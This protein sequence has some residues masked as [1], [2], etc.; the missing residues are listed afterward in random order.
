MIEINVIYQLYY[1][2][3]NKRI[4]LLKLEISELELNINN[5]I[6]ILEK[7]KNEINKYS[8]YYDILDR[9]IKKIKNNTDNTII[10]Y[11]NIQILNYNS[12]YTPLN[13]KRKEVIKL[14]KQV[15]SSVIYKKIIKK[16]NSK[17]IDKIIKDH[18]TFILPFSLGTLKV[19]RKTNKR[20]RPNWGISNK[21]YKLLITQNKI[22][23]KLT[24]HLEAKKNNKEY[25]GVPWLHYHDETDLWFS[26]KT[27]KLAKVDIRNYRFKPSRG[28]KSVVEKLTNHK[29]TLN[30]IEFNK[31]A[32]G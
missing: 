29:K 5:T 11:I 10:K 26:W 7:Y 22:P 8:N 14:S 6:K 32:E 15:L 3:I 23:Y 30:L 16:F 27:F 24:D 17:L 13:L 4:E 1:A 18:Y 9:K 25:K 20:K 28:N 2:Y 21:N 12:I 31:Y 19:E